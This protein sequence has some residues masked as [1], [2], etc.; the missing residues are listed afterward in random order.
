[1]VLI[2]IH[3][4]CATNG[5]WWSN[6]SKGK[7]GP[8]V[9]TCVLNLVQDISENMAEN[10]WGAAQVQNIRWAFAPALSLI[11]HWLWNS[12]FCSSNL[13]TSLWWVFEEKG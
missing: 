5:I 7:R 6:E 9:M 2:Y 11:D 10:G 3:M 4:I 1:M 12:P 13:E 8:I